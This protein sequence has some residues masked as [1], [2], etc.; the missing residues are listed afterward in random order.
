MFLSACHFTPSHNTTASKTAGD[1]SVPP[2]L[3]IHYSKY[4]TASIIMI[5]FSYSVEALAVLFRLLHTVLSG[6]LTATK[7]ALKYRAKQHTH[8]T[9]PY[10]DAS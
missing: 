8:V 7:H 2:S 10:S 5:T 6:G 4:L 9:I 3:K 1:F